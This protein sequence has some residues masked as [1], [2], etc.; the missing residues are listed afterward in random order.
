MRYAVVFSALAAAL[1]AMAARAAGRASGASWL[2]VAIEAYLACG[3]AAIAVLYLLHEVGRP[4]ETAFSGRLLAWTVLLPYRLLAQ[5]MLRLLILGGREDGMNEVVPGLHLGRMPSAR[6][7]T[8]FAEL[9]VTA[10]LDLCAEF[11]DPR[12]RGGPPGLEWM[13]LPLL[14]GQPPSDGQ[15]R[16]AVQWIAARR[17]EGRTILVHCAQGH[18]RSATIVAAALCRLGLAT[19]PE[20]A[21]ARIRAARPRARPSRRQQEALDRFLRTEDP[22]A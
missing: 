5:G 15:F 9:G 17:A 22:D 10:V 16:A 4:A 8:R 7:R 1:L 21:L 14:D 2:L 3:L 18:G 6:E 20:D 19:G 11:P 13:Q 12:R